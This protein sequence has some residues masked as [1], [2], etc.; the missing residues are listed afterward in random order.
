MTSPID[1]FLNY[2]TFDT[3]SDDSSGT[4]PS[5]EGQMV[6][7]REIVKHLNDIGMQDITLDDNGYVMA[8]LPANIVDPEV[9]IP[10]IGFIA[11]LDTSPDMSG[12]DVKPRVVD[13]HGGGIVLNEREVIV[14]SPEIFTEMNDY[15]GQKL[16]VT[17][18]T[19]LLGADDKAGIASIMSAMKH[20]IDNNE[21]KHGKVRIAFSRRRDRA[22]SK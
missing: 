10:T 1:F 3:Q 13:Y 4:M 7:A 22:R 11:H 16:I 2:V 21:I 20:L 18:G 17:D 8:T 12:R 15:I 5:T 14:M 6:C 19:T 9:N